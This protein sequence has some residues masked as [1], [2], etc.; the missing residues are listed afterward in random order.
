MS[1]SA[2]MKNEEINEIKISEQ[3]CELININESISIDFNDD[4]IKD[5]MKK[6]GKRDIK[7]I[8]N[9]YQKYIQ[10]QL[11]NMMSL[12]TEFMRIELTDEFETQQAKLMKSFKKTK[13]TLSSEDGDTESND[14]ENAKTAAVKKL[15]KCYDFVKTFMDSQEFESRDSIE[16]SPV[17][18]RSVM[19]DFVKKEREANADKINVK[20]ES[21]GGETNKKIFK[22][23]GPLKTIIEECIKKVKEDI[24]LVE[25][26]I[27]DRKKSKPDEGSASFKEIEYMETWVSE[28]K[29]LT[30]VPK[31]LQFTDFMKYSPF[32]FEE[33]NTLEK[34]KKKPPAPKK[35][36]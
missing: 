27:K 5:M 18:I 32:C 22:I 7:A 21:D 35:E 30:E 31:T 16:Y 33:R 19:N 2:E 24:T 20:P 4:T 3:F 28:K 36:A 8:M 13:K 6:C 26:A 17:E 15:S 23:Y 9:T 14:G 29:K 34:A 25:K 10:Q 12:K 1:A 11:D